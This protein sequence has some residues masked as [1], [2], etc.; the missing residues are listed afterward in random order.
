MPERLIFALYFS[1]NNSPLELK[2]VDKRVKLYRAILG[3]LPCGSFITEYLIDRIQGQRAERLI[4]Y[5]ENLN[6]RLERLE[7]LE[8]T[9]SYEYTVLVEN[10]IIEATKPISNKRLEWISSI[11][12]PA[13]TPTVE[14][15]IFRKKA[16]QILTDISD[17]D[18]EYLIANM[19]PLLALKFHQTLPGK[20]F[21]SMKDK[22]KL[23]SHD[24]FISVLNNNRLSLH[25]EALIEKRLMLPEEDGHSIRNKIT[26]LG[27][28]FLFVLGELDAVR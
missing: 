3:V 24:L 13:I 9:K 28:L 1:M 16:L 12:A 26:D 14:E 7:N 23:P 27:R 21:I 11:V 19:D 6:I 18:V 5:I 2:A 17:K 22:E 8:F 25:R 20:I 15:I 4:A 10:S